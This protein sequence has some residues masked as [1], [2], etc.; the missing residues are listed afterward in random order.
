MKRIEVTRK[1][2]E[3]AARMYRTNRDAIRALG[4]G[5]NTFYKLCKEF[6]IEMPVQRMR[7]MRNERNYN[8]KYDLGRREFGAIW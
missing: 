3:R 2:V 1:Q 4:I 5:N 8:R 6:N 7:R